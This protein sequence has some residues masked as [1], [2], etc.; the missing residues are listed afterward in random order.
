VR[1]VRVRRNPS[2]AD[3]RLP[4]RR[5]LSRTQNAF[6]FDVFFEGNCFHH[7]HLRPYRPCGA[8]P[9]ESGSHRVPLARPVRMSL[10]CMPLSFISLFPT[11][12]QCWY[13]KIG[14][15]LSPETI[16]PFIESTFYKSY[17]ILFNLIFVHYLIFY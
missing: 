13:S 10:C 2:F 5:F 4:R 6:Y 7:S 15:A 9:Q 1:R 3:D 11:P 12:L 14:S 8:V 17:L 16:I